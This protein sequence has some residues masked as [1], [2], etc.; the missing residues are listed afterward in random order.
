MIKW[1]Y[2]E[3]GVA[4]S[5]VYFWV[6]STGC[7]GEFHVAFKHFAK[8]EQS[9]LEHVLPCGLFFSLKPHRAFRIAYG[10]QPWSVKPWLSFDVNF[11]L[12]SSD[13]ALLET[14]SPS[15]YQENPSPSASRHIRNSLRMYISLILNYS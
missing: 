12:K 7:S 8:S 3:F 1:E 15:L 2:R 10:K 11:R 6:N 9:H 13:T 4:L 14:I 5:F